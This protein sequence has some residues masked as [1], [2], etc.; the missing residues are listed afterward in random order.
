VGV[1]MIQST[2]RFRAAREVTVV[3]SFNFLSASPRA[4]DI[5]GIATSSF[6]SGDTMRRSNQ[7]GGMN[8]RRYLVRGHGCRDRRRTMIWSGGGWVVRL[9]LQVPMVI[10]IMRSAESFVFLILVLMGFV[11]SA[12]TPLRNRQHFF[13][14][15]QKKAIR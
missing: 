6:S 14:I 1:E 12:I 8:S 9:T 3:K 4:L 13:L 7:V 2:V 15:S 5:L 11:P 10:G